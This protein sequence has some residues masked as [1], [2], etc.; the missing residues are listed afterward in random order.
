MRDL[1]KR[2]KLECCIK[3]S[4]S[5]GLH[6]YVPFNTKGITFND[7]KSLARA[8]AMMMEEQD[9][10][11]VARLK[12]AGAIRVGK[13]NVPEFAAGS[14]TFNTLFGATHNPYRHGL[15]A[16]GSSG[17]A[18]AALAAGLVPLAEGSAS[19]RSIGTF[20]RIVPK[21]LVQA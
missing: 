14:H 5:K 16:G 2:L 1:F 20:S 9:E 17:G 13:T 3:S 7:T 4:G 21:R 15:S 12:A 18:A 6:I 11:V 19:A 10:L 8:V